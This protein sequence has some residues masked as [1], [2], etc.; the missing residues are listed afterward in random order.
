MIQ[1]R[2]H[3]DLT[4]HQTIDPE[5]ERIFEKTFGV[6]IEFLLAYDCP[7]SFDEL[8]GEAAESSQPGIS[9]E[10]TWTVERDPAEEARQRIVEAFRE[11]GLACNDFRVS[12]ESFNCDQW[13]VASDGT[14]AERGELEKSHLYFA[15]GKTIE[16]TPQVWAKL[17]LTSVEVKSRILPAGQASLDEIMKAVDVILQFDTLV[18]YTAGLHIHVGAGRLPEAGGFDLR[19]L[20]NLMEFVTVAPLHELHSRDRLNN[21]FCQLPVWSFS[22]KER[23]PAAIV[24]RFETFTKVR[25]L[26]TFVHTERWD[27]Q[28]VAKGLLLKQGAVINNHRAYNLLNLEHG[29]AKQTVSAFPLD[30]HG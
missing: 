14:V 2:R 15:N 18:N 23:S 12:R 9:T 19:T 1:L 22:R 5:D 24:R 10:L 17:F 16:L 28:L 6:E 4:L 26:I 30:L 25:D 21:E 8:A 3:L 29:M 13:E 7:N 27:R 11:A 20:K